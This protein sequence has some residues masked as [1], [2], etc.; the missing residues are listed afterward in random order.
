M[1]VSVKALGRGA[2][3]T[4]RMVI[5]PPEEGEGVT[6]QEVGFPLNNCQLAAAV[7]TEV[8]ATRDLGSYMMG[9]LPL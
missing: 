8:S 7:V 3:K 1:T 6:P 2:S 9:Q 4:S 5:S